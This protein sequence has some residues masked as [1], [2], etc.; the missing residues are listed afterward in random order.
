[1][2]VCR[3]D[4]VRELLEM[5]VLY[6]PVRISV[7]DVDEESICRGRVLVVSEMGEV[8]DAGIDSIV[9]WVQSFQSNSEDGVIV[10]VEEINFANLAEQYSEIV[11]PLRLANADMFHLH[12]YFNR[13]PFP[14]VFKHIQ[15]FFERNK[16]IVSQDVF[17]IFVDQLEKLEDEI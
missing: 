6:G 4:Q 9:E 12:E 10:N 2:A 3:V 16:A 1:M 8:D 7:D 13:L 14:Q 11:K 17:D 5:H 15:L